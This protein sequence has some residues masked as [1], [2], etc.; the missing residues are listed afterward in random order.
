MLASSMLTSLEDRRDATFVRY[1]LLVDAN[2]RN[3]RLQP[4]Y[5]LTTSYGQLQHI[6]VVTLRAAVELGLEEPET[7][8]LAAVTE[9]EITAHNDLDM[10]YYRREHPVQ[11]VEMT[12]I[13]CLVGRIK[14]TN[15]HDWVII[16]RSGSLAR[17]HY[18]PDV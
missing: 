12:S 10:H 6:F 9:C 11:I 13:Q 3:S 16:D 15:G 7:I 1:A 4:R 8:I 18:D 17:P 5:V 2:A 14:T